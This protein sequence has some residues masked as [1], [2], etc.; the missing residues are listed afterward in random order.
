MMRTI[1]IFA[2]C[3]CALAIVILGAWLPKLATNRQT[4][5]N[6]VR[7]HPVQELSL[8][9]QPLTVIDRLCLSTLTPQSIPTA[10]DNAHT[11]REA[12]TELAYDCFFEYSDALTGL[13]PQ[14]EPVNCN[15]TYLL[16]VGEGTG[17]TIRS[18]HYW[19]AEFTSDS[20]DSDGG[21]GCT[22][23]VTFDDETGMLCNVY[24]NANSRLGSAGEIFDVLNKLFW[25]KL[26]PFGIEH[27][28]LDSYENEYEYLGK[29]VCVDPSTGEKEQ[30]LIV[31]G[32]GY[33]NCNVYRAPRENVM[34][35]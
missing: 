12:A 21:Y 9:E 26:E 1:R 34:Q 13:F 35:P 6:E 7:E 2:A 32:N 28:L 15:L 11:T 20:G 30:A 8:T 31:V 5:E 16:N 4:H 24:C 18:N 14:W 23:I 19:R 25:G 27:Q 10:E 3:L 29:Y 33:Y 22:F 17:G